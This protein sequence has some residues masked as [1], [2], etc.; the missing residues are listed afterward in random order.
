MIIKDTVK[1]T[2][3]E[4]TGDIKKLSGMSEVFISCHTGSHSFITMGHMIQIKR[5]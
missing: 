2:S 1:N 3:R 5:E 4:Y